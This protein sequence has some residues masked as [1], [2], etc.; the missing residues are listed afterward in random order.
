LKAKENESSQ[1]LAKE[2]SEQRQA[3]AILN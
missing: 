1:S 3:A 2:A